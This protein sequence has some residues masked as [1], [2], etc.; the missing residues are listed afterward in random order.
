M[1]KK[2]VKKTEIEDEVEEQEPLNLVTAFVEDDRVFSYSCFDTAHPF[3]QAT[4]EFRGS[5]YKTAAE[6]ADKIKYEDGE[7]AWDYGTPTHPGSPMRKM[8]FGLYGKYDNG[9]NLSAD[10]FDKTRKDLVGCATIKDWGWGE[11]VDEEAGFTEENVL[12]VLKSLIRSL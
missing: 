5:E 4:V 8:L 2:I 10:V 7:I 1:P 11:F 3:V 6:A 12:K 9:W